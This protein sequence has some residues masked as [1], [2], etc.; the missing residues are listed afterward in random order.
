MNDGSWICRS[1]IV[2]WEHVCSSDCAHACLGICRPE[3]NLV[4]LLRKL[5]IL[6]SPFFF[7]LVREHERQTY[8]YRD[9]DRQTDWW[10]QTQGGS[11]NWNWPVNLEN[12]LSRSSALRLQGCSNAF[13]FLFYEFWMMGLRSSLSTK[14]LPP[15]LKPK[16]TNSFRSTINNFIWPLNYTQA[17]N[18]HTNQERWMVNSE[19]MSHSYPGHRRGNLFLGSKVP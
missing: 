18:P 5:S 11:L 13:S 1:P 16:S 14:L 6:L 2:C 7:F 17:E 8:T 12:Q 19:Q 10:T 4:L 15:L 9:T 3:H